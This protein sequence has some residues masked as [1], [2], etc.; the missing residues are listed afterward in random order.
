MGG[1]GAR[2]PTVL[3]EFKCGMMNFDGKMVTPNRARG[4]L[5]VVREQPGMTQFQWCDASGNAQENLMM[6]PGSAKFEKVKQTED[7]VY[8]LEI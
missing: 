2:G 3:V 5:K 4:T 1:F 7:R 6:I 8:L